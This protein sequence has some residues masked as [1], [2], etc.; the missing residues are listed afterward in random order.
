M[1][2]SYQT[3]K[4]SILITIFSLLLATSVYA[5]T[6]ATYYVD[7]GGSD[8]SGNGSS[9]A[10][11]RTVAYAL[12]KV[13]Y[14]NTI[15]I[16]DGTY[17][18]NQLVVPPGVNLKSTSANS[19]KVRL[20][21]KLSLSSYKPFILL[22]SAQPGS[23]GGQS[24]SYLEIAG[25]NGSYS[26]R[27]GISVQNRNNVRIHHNYIHDFTGANGSYGVLAE[28]TQ[29]ARTNKWWDYMP[30][31]AQ[32]PGNDANM[33]E[34]WPSNPVEGFELDNNTIIRCGYRITKDD[35]YPSIS[36]YNLKDSSIHHNNVDTGG[37][38]TECIFAT[39]AFLW[40]V[41]VYNNTL[42]MDLL[43]DRASYIIELWNMRSGCEFYNNVVNASFS[44]SVGK[45]THVYRN[46]IEYE[47]KVD[48]GIGIEFMYQS[49]GS[50]YE[51]FISNGP[52]YGIDVGSEGGGPLG[53]IA[54]NIIVRNNVIHNTAGCGIVAFVHGQK[55]TSSV[56]LI[57]G[58]QIINNTIDGIRSGVFAGI[59][60]QQQDGAQGDAIL[61]DV[62]VANN[63]VLNNPSYSGTTQGT[64]QN[65]QIER[66]LFWRNG[67]NDW[68]GGSA[69][70]VSTIIGDPMIAG[71]SGTYN[72][73]QI[74]LDNMDQSAAVDAGLNVGLPYVGGGPDIGA[75]EAGAADQQLLP[76]LLK[77]VG[78][79]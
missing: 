16:N 47:R 38:E 30:A 21:P 60:V 35:I 52:L 62:V 54:R 8:S 29:I 65:L 24:I 53:Y 41:D 46:K 69:N 4:S 18:E 63:M 42:R 48:R 44:L 6:A 67:F 36:I 27:V 75:F 45:E 25:V 61:R 19:S 59:M 3:F 72:G 11:W 23:Q 50:V 32:E 31:D 2:I 13:A 34:L 70:D 76:P 49:E 9:S 58:I 79:N 10:P 64:V 26:A 55:Y 73:Y 56:N 51:N 66:N 20:Q 57:H 77:I 68:N 5:A 33:D 14:G 40:N 43:S 15:S 74:P 37:I 12:G 1:T 7:T 22:S 17:S 28:S 71:P 78:L 39:S